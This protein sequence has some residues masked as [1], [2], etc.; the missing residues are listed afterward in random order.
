MRECGLP[1]RDCVKDMRKSGRDAVIERNKG[2]QTQNGP[3][4]MN[5]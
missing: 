3:N 2:R 5:I 1:F 4:A